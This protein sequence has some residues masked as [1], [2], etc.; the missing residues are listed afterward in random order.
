MAPPKKNNT[1]W[2]SWWLNQPLWKIPVK[3]MLVKFYH[4]HR[5]WGENKKS[6]KPPTRESIVAF[7]WGETMPPKLHL[8]HTVPLKLTVQLF[9]PLKISLPCGPQKGRWLIFPPCIWRSPPG[10]FFPEWLPEVKISSQKSL[11]V[12]VMVVLNI[13]YPFFMCFGC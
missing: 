7:L 11:L 12:P 6:L 8:T 5:D 1:A 10:L 3:N 9:T 13:V 2:T 4:F